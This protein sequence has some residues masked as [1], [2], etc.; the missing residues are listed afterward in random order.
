MKATV[1]GT[2]GRY[3]RRKN[4]KNMQQDVEANLKYFK[5]QLKLVKRSTKRNLSGT[6]ESRGLKLAKLQ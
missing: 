2:H 3:R 4:I 1:P 6:G 5:G